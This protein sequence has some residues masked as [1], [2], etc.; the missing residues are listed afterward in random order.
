MED[1]AAELPK[2]TVKFSRISLL[3]DICVITVSAV[4]VHIKYESSF[5][6]V[7]ALCWVFGHMT[8]PVIVPSTAYSLIIID[9]N[10]W[11]NTHACSMQHKDMRQYENSGGHSHGTPYGCKAGGEAGQQG[12][13]CLRPDYIWQ[14]CRAEGIFPAYHK[15]FQE[16]CLF[17]SYHYSPFFPFLY[18]QCTWESAESQ[19]VPCQLIKSA[20]KLGENHFVQSKS[21][22]FKEC[23]YKC[24]NQW[25]PAE[26]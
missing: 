6:L 1:K 11:T 25:S 5:H 7:L 9:P 22:P 26:K 16:L 23:G 19:L 14:F 21:S 4:H 12:P 18:P 24:I 10:H 3:M 20:E 15:Q 17:L 8:L 2:D 13:W